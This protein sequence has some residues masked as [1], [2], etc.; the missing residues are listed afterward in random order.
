[1]RVSITR[2]IWCFIAIPAAILVFYTGCM[3]TENAFGSSLDVELQGIKIPAQFFVIKESGGEYIN[4][5]NFKKYSAL[6]IERISAGGWNPSSYGDADTYLLLGYGVEPFYDT[7]TVIKPKYDQDKN[8]T[9][10]VH[11]GAE[12]RNKPF[13]RI[14]GLNAEDY[15]LERKKTVLF[16]LLVTDPY[17]GEA[18]ENMI[19]KMVMIGAK[20][21]F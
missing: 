6:L 1:M 20:T 14:T 8:T 3:S 7:D 11:T 5:I 17:G 12:I 16:T 13:V 10:W 4:N 9:A 19:E 21:L 15:R 18:S 2:Y